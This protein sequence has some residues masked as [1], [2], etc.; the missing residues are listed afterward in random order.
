[1]ASP[2]VSVATV[3]SRHPA[4][5]LSLLPDGKGRGLVA[6]VPLEPGDVI[7]TEEAFCWHAGPRVWSPG[8][9]AALL[10]QRL[11]Q[12][13]PWHVDSGDSPAAAL[14]PLAELLQGAMRANAFHWERSGEG[15]SGVGGADAAAAAHS[16]L[17]D[18]FHGGR[19]EEGGAS[20]TGIT[21]EGGAAEV[22]EDGEGTDRRALMQV[23]CLAN[24]SCAPVAKVQ[25]VRERRGRGE[26]GGGWAGGWLPRVVAAR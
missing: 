5:A 7:V 25:Q 15:W 24:H 10:A 21:A 1:M 18:G 2:L 4:V 20:G 12:M 16:T 17:V 11:A 8:H 6:A 22:E 14:P 3:V 23:I 13:A 19:A 9:D 26:G